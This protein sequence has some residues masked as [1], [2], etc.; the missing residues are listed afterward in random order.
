MRHYEKRWILGSRWPLL[1]NTPLG[2]LFKR[3]WQ[4]YQ[5]ICQI[6]RIPWNCSH[7]IEIVIFDSPKYWCWSKHKKSLWRPACWLQ[8]ALA[9]QEKTVAQGSSVSYNM[10]FSRNNWHETLLGGFVSHQLWLKP[11]PIVRR[12]AKVHNS[13]QLL[14]WEVFDSK[15]C[16]HVQHPPKPSLLISF[17]SFRNFEKKKWKKSSF[18]FVVLSNNI[19]TSAQQFVV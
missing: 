15:Q 18:N 11:R 10:V 6:S 7:K 19:L 12:E 14:S 1:D 5:K 17:K 2:A 16:G 8:P 3:E 9:K 4:L 13:E